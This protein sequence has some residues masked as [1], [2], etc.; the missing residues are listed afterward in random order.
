MWKIW[1]MRF[2]RMHTDSPT[3]HIGIPTALKYNS[4]SHT[5]W[6]V[7]PYVGFSSSVK[8]NLLV[9]ELERDK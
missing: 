3:G 2:T 7:D 1:I 4:A 6:D 9:Q 8:P 5:P